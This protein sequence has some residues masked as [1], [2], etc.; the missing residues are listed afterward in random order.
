L[1]SGALRE[2]GGSTLGDEGGFCR[3]LIVTINGHKLSD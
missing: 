2:V 3:V 1:A